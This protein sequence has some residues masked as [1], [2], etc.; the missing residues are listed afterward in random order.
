MA[1]CLGTS[2]VLYVR[3]ESRLG[4]EFRLTSFVEHALEMNDETLG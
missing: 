3:E 2:H 4:F 1:D